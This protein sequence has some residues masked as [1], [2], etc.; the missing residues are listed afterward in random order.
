MIERRANE[1]R[2]YRRRRNRGPN[3]R[4][5]S[6]R[7]ASGLPSVASVREPPTSRR[8]YR[9]RDKPSYS[10]SLVERFVGFYVEQHNR[11]TPHSTFEGR[12]P[13]KVYFGDRAELE[14]GLI[15]ARHRA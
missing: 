10:A 15:E 2:T 5:A 9:L 6:G 12:T 7:A 8:W 11:V 13:D 4:T 14:Q 1:E 3:G